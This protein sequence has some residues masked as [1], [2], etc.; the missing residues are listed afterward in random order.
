MKHEG[1][2]AHELYRRHSSINLLPRLRLR[3]LCASG[4]QR[5]AFRARKPTPVAAIRAASTSQC[6]LETLSAKDA[7]NVHAECYASI[8]L[9]VRRHSLTRVSGNQRTFTPRLCP[10]A[11]SDTRGLVCSCRKAA[12]LGDTT[13]PHGLSTE[14]LTGSARGQRWGRTTTCHAMSCR[15]CI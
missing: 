10:A 14:L 2:F 6:E 13:T 9:F 12:L 4:R 7:M 11:N 3:S 8:E 5:D 15:A 1:R